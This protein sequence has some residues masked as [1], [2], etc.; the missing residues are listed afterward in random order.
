MRKNKILKAYEVLSAQK[1]RMFLRAAV[2]SFFLLG[3]NTYA[4]FVFFDK[5]D[6]NINADVISWDVTFFDEEESV[7]SVAITIDSLYPG[8]DNYVKNV[9][10]QNESDVSADF[11]YV[12]NSITLFGVTYTVD[13]NVTSD[14][15]IA[16]LEDEFPFKITFSKS[17]DNLASG[18][19]TASFSVYA[20]WP[21][22][23]SESYILLNHYYEYDSMTEYYDSS[24]NLDTTVTAD[25]FSD[26]LESGL[27]VES[28]SADSYWGKKASNFKNDNQDLPCLLLEMKLIVSQ[29]QN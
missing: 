28:D 2:M 14:D 23:A 11:S 10:V 3:V 4:W 26:K 18:G 22:E 17:K 12:V 20:T 24:Y 9:S 5:F 15:L 1:K 27:Y 8:M 29:T 19:D 7:N 25:N 16:I 13:D 21:F 6:G